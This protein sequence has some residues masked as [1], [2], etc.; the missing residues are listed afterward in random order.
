MRPSKYR[1]R[2][3]KALG[4]SDS[5]ESTEANTRR[6]LRQHSAVKRSAV[7]TTL[8]KF[9]GQISS[10]FDETFLEDLIDYDMILD[11]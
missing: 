11:G 3:N 8:R 6:K 5:T 7:K 9:S 10:N 4:I 1:R 2:D